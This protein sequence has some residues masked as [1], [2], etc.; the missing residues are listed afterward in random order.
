MSKKLLKLQRTG[1]SFDLKVGEAVVENTSQNVNTQTVNV[2][3]NST[4]STTN[5]EIGDPEKPVKDLKDEI[6]KIFQSII[7]D[8]QKALINIIDKSGSV[9]IGVKE[10]I[11]LIS[12]LYEVDESEI[13]INIDSE[14]SYCCGL[15]VSPLK[16][17]NSIKI[18]KSNQMMFYDLN[19]VDNAKYNLLSEQ[20]NISL[21]FTIID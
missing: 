19:V 18:K 2:F 14:E 1:D 8:D 7:I 3:T 9:I 16:K 10:L 5:R 6:I 20:Y 21:I 12:I 13:K 17:I 11:L 4:P 15:K